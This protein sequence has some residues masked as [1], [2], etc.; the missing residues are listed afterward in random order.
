MSIA[1]VSTS[2]GSIGAAATSLAINAPASIAVGD[3]LIATLAIDGGSNN[4][5]TLPAG[6]T[7]DLDYRRGT[8]IKILISHRVVDGS[9]GASFTWQ[10][11]TAN[12]MC[13]GIVAYRGV[14]TATV[15]EVAP[16]GAD[17]SAGTA[18]HPGAT[19]L[20]ANAWFL[21]GLAIDGTGTTTTAAS[22]FT[23]EV[24]ITT[25]RG[26]E[27]QDKAQATPGAS[28]ALSSTLGVSRQWATGLGA[29]KAAVATGL[30][31]GM[32]ITMAQPLVAMEI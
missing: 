21:W 7:S 24:S 32:R 9:E 30:P 27:I 25:G 16:T 28:G 8:A 2:S 4:T 6:W 13:G 19:S 12:L 15:F 14:D 3:V 17:G 22:G 26:S 20:S 23:Q 10:T 29:I 18:T 11:S 5:M 31:P 1:V